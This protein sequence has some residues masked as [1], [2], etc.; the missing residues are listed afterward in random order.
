MGFTRGDEDV[1]PF[2]FSGRGFHGGA[3]NRLRLASSAPGAGVVQ[4]GSRERIVWGSEGG[5][6]RTDRRC[7]SV[8]GIGPL[9]H[10][11][12]AAIALG[13]RGWR[14]EADHPD[15]PLLDGSAKPWAR[16]F[17]AVSAGSSPRVGKCSLPR[18]SWVGASRGRLE[19][20]PSDDFELE[21][22]WTRGP[23]G[24]ERWEGGAPDLVRILPART[25]IEVGDWV[26]ARQAGLLQ[27][28]GPRSG[29]LI[30]PGG[31]LDR[32]L[33]EELHAQGMEPVGNA[34]TGGPERLPMECAAHKALDL[35]GDIGCAIGYLPSLRIHARD[36]GHALHAVLC[37]ALRIAHRD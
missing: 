5:E 10:L 23:D 30:S 35:V 32:T 7:T 24:P 22:E 29:R 8:E 34:W 18:N 37:R 17:L 31:N 25:F 4:I 13:V 1:S 21:V 15:L 20:E 9:E 27:G 19:I 14:L 6:A 3:Q 11:S 2:S 36:A 26:L 28:A 16:A 12:A 33:L